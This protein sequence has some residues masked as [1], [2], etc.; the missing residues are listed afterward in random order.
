M[1]SLFRG[2]LSLRYRFPVSI[3]SLTTATVFLEEA[4]RL[5][6]GP[7]VSHVRF[8]ADAAER[9]ARA[10]GMNAERAYVLG[11]L[12]DIG[13][14]EGV[15]N[16][17]HLTDGYR[18]MRGHGFEDAARVCITHAYPIKDA[19]LFIG[20]WD[21]EAADGALLCDVLASTAYNDEDELIQLCDAL[22]L[23]SGFC[24][25]EKRF[26]DVSLRYGTPE[27]IPRK[28]RATLEIQ[29]RFETRIGASLYT[30]LPGVI[31]NTFGFSA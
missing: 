31:E 29:K 5:N 7:W 12:H 17:R 14:R 2:R 6:P 16:L 19:S 10:A 27:F 20:P 1:R 25:L 13:R 30:L 8:V 26:V 9:I 28:W 3:P 15:N 24:L 11:L 23:P 22:A 18:F 4:S 21:L